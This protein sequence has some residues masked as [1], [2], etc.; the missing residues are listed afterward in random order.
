MR[1]W[2]KLLALL[3]A[4]VMALGLTVTGFADEDKT[5]EAEPAEAVEAETGKIV[6]LH[7]NDVHCGIDYELDEEGNLKKMGYS[8]LAAYKAEMEAKYGEENVTLVDAGDAIQGETIG[9]LTDGEYIVKIMNEV[10]YD[11]AI[12]GNHEFDFQVPNLLSLAKETAEYKY[13]CCNFM[14]LTTNEAA[15]DPY[16]IV[17]YGDVKVAYVGIS[18]PETFTSSTPTYFQNEEG[19]FVYSFSEGEDG[20]KLYAAVQEA[21]DAATEEG[22]D[23]VVAIAHLGVEVPESPYSSTSV[24][25]NTT[26]I[27]VVIDGHSHTVVENDTQKNKDGKDVVVNQTGTK[28]AN[29]GKIVIDTE[30][31][32][33]TAELVNDYAET[34]EEI[35]AFIQSMHDEF[36]EMLSEVIGSSEADLTFQKADGE[37]RAVRNEE[38]NL[39]DLVA[40]AF[41]LTTGADIAFMNGGGI[42]ANAS[43]G[44]VTYGDIVNVLPFS[45]SIC[46]MEVTGQIV[47]DALEW[48]SKDA[49]KENGG[50]L[51]VSGISYTI[52]T[53]IPSSVTVDD[54]GLFTGVEGERRV[55]D[56]MV[57]DEP[58]DPEKTYV[59]AGHN[60]MLKN[61]GDGF[62]MFEGCKLIQDETMMQ[63]QALIDFITKNLEGTIPADY[64]KAQG[65]IKVLYTD[66]SSEDWF[67]D[68]V[69]FVT[70]EGL[71]D[72]ASPVATFEPET[73]TTRAVLAEA[74]YRMAG[75]P[76]VTAENTFTDVADDASY[77]NAVIWA[78][79]AGVVGGVNED[80]TLF[81]PEAPVYRRDIATMLARF[82]KAEVS[83]DEIDLSKF[84][85]ADSIADYAKAY[86]SWA[87]ANS[88]LGGDG[89]GNMNPDNTA[90]RSEIAIILQRFAPLYEKAA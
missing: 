48:G 85:D 54:H 74:L 37:T 53:N 27:D 21:V 64:A 47:L 16:E 14:D 55:S 86:V 57:G 77:K 71:M 5:D 62:T 20:A 34:N 56:V 79:E 2:N 30:T 44:D 87:A 52:N 84:G 33:I 28:F 75:S 39:G 51:Q 11:L 40:D 35:D 45:N 82:I 42:R 83:E 69:A 13:L 1:K 60:Y 65:R 50:F 76:E 4:M 12:P 89:E 41:R 25:A 26:G 3:L 18:T 43:A 36:E 72:A 59:L 90:K 7:T 88:L 58:I 67:K 68:A 32:D 78:K 10:G 17:T 81:E 63:S 29:I 73:A 19:E 70:K 46:T 23:Y 66:V 38:T 22:A 24:I 9:N 61:C 6:I 15:F 80:G 8:N 31:G 49:P